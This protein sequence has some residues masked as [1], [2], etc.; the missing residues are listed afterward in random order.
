M[1]IDRSKTIEQLENEY[2]QEPPHTSYLVRTCYALRAKPLALFTPED[3]RMMIGQ[4]RNLQY[5]V[6]IAL[7]KL[8]NNILSSGD[9]YDGDLLSNLLRIDM[10]YWIKHP[11]QKTDLLKMIS[12]QWTKIVEEELEG[13]ISDFVDQIRS[14]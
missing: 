10:V 8:E 14:L 1:N 6:P 2:W 11:K 3:L 12:N 5:L 9:M 13:E 4:Q 7:E